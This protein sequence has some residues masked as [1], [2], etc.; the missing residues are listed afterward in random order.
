MLM[1][2]LWARLS[3]SDLHTKCS[4][5]NLL[6]ALQ[7]VWLHYDDYHGTH[8]YTKVVYPYSKV[9]W[10]FHSSIH[11][12]G[13]SRWSYT[14]YLRRES[15]PPSN[16]AYIMSSHAH[17]NELKRFINRLVVIGKESVGHG[18]HKEWRGGVWSTTFRFGTPSTDLD[19]HCI[20][21]RSKLKARFNMCSFFSAFYNLLYM[22]TLV[23]VAINWEGLRSE[24]EATH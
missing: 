2:R 20:Y 9:V 14:I 1:P 13:P 3:T 12:K 17:P 6:G 19:R 15:A 10:V 16:N 5:G 8:T 11:K 18:S 24:I 21:W 4:R 23:Q 22:V 7:M